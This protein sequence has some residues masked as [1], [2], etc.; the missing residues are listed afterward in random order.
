MIG[1]AKHKLAVFLIWAGFRLLDEDTREEVFYL[2]GVAG[3]KRI[4]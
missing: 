2:L 1:Y 4:I 3:R